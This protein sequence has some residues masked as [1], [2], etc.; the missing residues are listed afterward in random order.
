MIKKLSL[1]LGISMATAGLAEPLITAEPV[2]TTKTI[3][4][5]KTRLIEILGRVDS[6]IVDKANDLME[7]SNKSNMPV[8][9]L[10]N[11]P[12]GSVAAGNVFI[13]AMRIAKSRGVDV[14]CI[15]SIYAASMAFSILANC[16]ERF[17]L[18]N[19][20][21]LFHPA[22]ISLMGMFLQEDMQRFSDDLKTINDSLKEFLVKNLGID[23]NVMLKAFHDEKWWTPKELQK[24]TKKGWLKVV[25]D[26]TGIDN[27]F[28]FRKPKVK[29]RQE[30]KNKGHEI[31]Y[32]TKTN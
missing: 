12:G 18:P 22:R 15:T 19:S 25:K 29:S 8:Y 26:V 10:I 32:E 7:L 23:K 20:K 1:V 31:V 11:S 30:V 27:L 4:V 17:V 14:K 21:L 2:S 16:S 6:Q 5:D 9:L 28:N 24:V 3:H 13:D